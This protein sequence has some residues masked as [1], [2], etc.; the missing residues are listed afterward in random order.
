MK[1]LL[2]ESEKADITSEHM[3]RFDFSSWKFLGGN[4]HING[5]TERMC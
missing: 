4:R 2:G 3:Q 1:K 5:K